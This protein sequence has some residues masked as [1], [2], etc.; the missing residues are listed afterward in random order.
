MSLLVDTSVW[1]DHFRAVDARLAAL[2][3]AGEVRMHPFVLGELALGNFRDRKR[4]LTVLG[5]LYAAPLVAQECF[6]DFVERHAL[7]GIGIGFVD[8]HLLASACEGR[9]K[10]WTRDQRLAARAEILGVG[11][12]EPTS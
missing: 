8:A 12:V 4:A 10:L 5:S 9:I 11:W 6:L 3:G 2:L 1:V 7:A